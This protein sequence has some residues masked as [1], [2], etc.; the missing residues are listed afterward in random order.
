[1]D[2]DPPLPDWADYMFIR[3]RV[4]T[5]ASIAING[6]IQRHKMIAA[7]ENHDDNDHDHRADSKKLDRFHFL[8]VVS[9]VFVLNRPP[10]PFPRPR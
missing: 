10:E 6:T 4:D 9:S 3:F 7:I 5:A 2:V 1:M 8:G